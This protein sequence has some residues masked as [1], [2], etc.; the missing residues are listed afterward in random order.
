MKQFAVGLTLAGLLTVAASAQPTFVE[1]LSLTPA[2]C[3]QLQQILNQNGY[4]TVNG[5]YSQPVGQQVLGVLTPQQQWQLQQM[6]NQGAFNSGGCPNQRNQAYY[7]N[8]QGRS[9]RHHRH[10]GQN[11]GQSGNGSCGAAYNSNVPVVYAPTAPTYPN[12][13]YAYPS[14][15]PVYSQ[16]NL[17]I[18]LLTGLLNS[19]ILNGVFNR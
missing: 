8:G 7:P 17:G 11:W 15:P 13:A 1:Q 2:Q 5:G 3:Q 6:A 18:N 14:G 12:Y 16:P 10:H 19:G 4:P 9:G